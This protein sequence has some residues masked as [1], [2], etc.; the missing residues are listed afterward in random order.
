M[1]YIII[2]LS[3]YSYNNIIKQLYNDFRRVIFVTSASY[4]MFLYYSDK[5]KLKIKMWNQY[6]SRSWRWTTT[7]MY[8]NDLCRWFCIVMYTYSVHLCT[9]TTHSIFINMGF[10]CLKLAWEDKYRYIIVSVSTRRIYAARYQR[11]IY[12]RRWQWINSCL[13]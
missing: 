3:I 1:Y 8:M 5:H 9:T 12:L 10:Y 6:T 4:G 11:R 2:H 7:I 13:S